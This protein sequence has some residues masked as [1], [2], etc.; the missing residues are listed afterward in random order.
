MEKGTR[1]SETRNSNDR[2]LPSKLAIGALGVGII[3][4]DALCPKGETISEGLDRIID[5]GKIE[6]AL[7]RVSGLALFMHCA[8]LFP[9][10]KYDPI[11]QVGKLIRKDK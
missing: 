4:Y 6:A 9:D 2:H 8:N 3:G 7:V 10:E 5:R 11:H 1:S